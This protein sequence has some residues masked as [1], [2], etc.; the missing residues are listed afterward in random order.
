MWVVYSEPG[1]G[2]V[3][4]EQRCPGDGDWAVTRPGLVPGQDQARNHLHQLHQQAS[5]SLLLL[6]FFLFLSF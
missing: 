6:S 5:G 4:G 2:G 3:H 1:G